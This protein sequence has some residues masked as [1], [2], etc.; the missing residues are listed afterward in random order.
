MATLA[1]GIFAILLGLIFK[2]Q[3]VAFMVGLAFAIAASANFPSLL[4]SILWKGLTT[5]GTT[6]SIVVGAFS[7]ILLIILSP[8]IMVDILKYETAIFPLK[9]PAMISI[10]ASF[11]TAWI[12]SL[13]SRESE[14]EAKFE[15]EKLRSY[16][17]V[18]A[19]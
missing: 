10:P 13:G 3:N 15:R 19:E 16:L 4:L 17:G 9:N 6:A 18:G 1:L 12:V 2:G 14:A 8:T 7:A 11:L 5:K